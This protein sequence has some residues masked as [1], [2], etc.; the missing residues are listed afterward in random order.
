MRRFDSGQ[1]RQRVN[2][3]VLRLP[4]QPQKPRAGCSTC[5]G[6]NGYRPASPPASPT[7]ARLPRMRSGGGKQ[8]RRCNR[9]CMIFLK[10]VTICCM[11]AASPPTNVAK[12]WPVRTEKHRGGAGLPSATACRGI[13]RDLSSCGMGSKMLSNCKIHAAGRPAAWPYAETRCM[14]RGL[15]PLLTPPL[16]PANGGTICGRQISRGSS[17]RPPRTTYF[18][19]RQRARGGAFPKAG[20]KETRKDEQAEKI[21]RQHAE[22]GCGCLF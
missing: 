7:D 20:G 6:Q 3:T 13:R 12:T 14:S 19:T 21:H 5:Q 8:Q 22:K 11:I 10:S 1:R 2:F 4:S 18:P 16:V 9:S 15:Q 17:G